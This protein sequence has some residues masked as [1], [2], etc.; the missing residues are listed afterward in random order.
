MESPAL[1]RVF[2]HGEVYFASGADFNDPYDCKVRCIVYDRSE[3]DYTKWAE[4]LIARRMP[5]MPVE[6]RRERARRAAAD[7]HRGEFMDRYLQS[8]V[9][10]IG[11]FSVSTTSEH[12]LLW[13]HYAHGH[14]GLCLKFQRDGLFVEDELNENLYPIYYRTRFPLVSEAADHFEQVRSIVLTKS[15]DWVYESEA[16]YLDWKRG[17]GCREFRPENLTAVIFGCRMK[18]GD[19]QRVRAWVA[20][21]P[22]NPRFYEVTVRDR[23]YEL[24]TRAI[25]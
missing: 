17:P 23:E 10:G 9:D 22:T 20:S 2:T 12:A 11:I 3:A 4:A 8:E 18:P 13:S 19:R 21:G 14:T 24:D 1:E 7:P 16:G 6:E 25:D 15:Y 5:S